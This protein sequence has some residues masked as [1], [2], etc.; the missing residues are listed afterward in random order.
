M[1]FASLEVRGVRSSAE[2]EGAA[3]RLVT[4]PLTSVRSLRHV[5]ADPKGRRMA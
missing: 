1:R 2:A 4:I 3:L 5:M